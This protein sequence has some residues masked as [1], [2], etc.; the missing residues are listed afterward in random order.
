VGVESRELPLPLP[1][2]PEDD[3][4]YKDTTSKGT[5]HIKARDIHILSNQY[6]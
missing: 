1:D 6:T 4:M 2:P 3:L 5:L